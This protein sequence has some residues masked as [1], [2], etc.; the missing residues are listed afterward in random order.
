MSAAV[1]LANQPA[2]SRAR[3]LKGSP[4][5]RPLALVAIAQ[6]QAIDGQIMIR[7]TA[8]PWSRGARAHAAVRFV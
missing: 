5:R 6:P 4:W 8:V 7:R 2:P 3:R 1:V